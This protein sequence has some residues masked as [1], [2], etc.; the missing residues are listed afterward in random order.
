MELPGTREEAGSTPTSVSCLKLRHDTLEASDCPGLL[1]RLGCD[2]GFAIDN[3]T[4]CPLCE[5]RNPCDP[6]VGLKCPEGEECQ[7]AVTKC[8][9]AP[10]CPAL[11][12][13]VSN[14]HSRQ[15]L[16]E[17]PSCPTGT[18]YQN[19]ENRTAECNPRS[20]AL[21]CP[22]GIKRLQITN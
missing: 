21:S 12:F 9:E 7:L 1:C 15:D 22:D 5:C 16:H 2:Y 20:R 19:A 10:F 6:V 11:P 18:P 13:C 8:A 3:E 17:E 14:Q 4:G